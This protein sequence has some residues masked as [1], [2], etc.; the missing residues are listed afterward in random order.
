M[1]TKRKIL[2]QLKIDR[3]YNGTMDVACTVFLLLYCALIPLFVNI[4]HYFDFKKIRIETG[5]SLC[6]NLHRWEQITFNQKR[7][8]NTKQYRCNDLK[9]IDQTSTFFITKLSFMF[10]SPV[11]LLLFWKVIVICHRFCHGLL[12]QLALLLFTGIQ[13]WIENFFVTL[14]TE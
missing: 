4:S 2:L 7:I 6:G 1:L 3:H 12:L 5:W 14:T 13:K 10:L 11:S 9:T 8:N